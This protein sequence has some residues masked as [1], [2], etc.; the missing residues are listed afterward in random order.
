M[1][2][3]LRSTLGLASAFLLAVN[4]AAAVAQ[5]RI[6]ASTRPDFN[7]DGKDDLAVGVPGENTGAGGVHIIYG[8]RTGL[9]ELGDQFFTQASP[10]IPGGEEDYDRCGVALTTGDFNGDGYADLAFGCPSE[11]TPASE[12]AAGAVMVLYGSST[13][14]RGAGSQ[15][16]S[17]N[18]PGINGGSETLDRCG[19]SL[20]SGDINRDGFADLVWGCPG[21]DVG[22]AEDA[23][24]INIVFGSAAGLTAAGNRFVSQDSSGMPDTAEGGDSCGT[25]VGA[26]DFNADGF[27]DVVFG[28]PGEDLGLLIDAG[29]VSLAFG[30]SS[31]ISG[32]SGDFVHQN[33]SRVS[34]SEGN[35]AFDKC[36]QG[37]GVAD[38]DNDGNEDLAI[39]CPGEDVGLLTLDAGGIVLL[40]GS[41]DARSTFRSG[42]SFVL[43]NAPSRRCGA[44]IATG[45]FNGDAF[46][47][48]AYGCPETA[49]GAGDVRILAGAAGFD[50]NDVPQTP[51]S[52]NSF[53]VPDSSEAGDNFGHA[54]S[55]GDFDGDGVTDLAIGAPN[56]DLA[57]GNN[58][59]AATV[60]YFP[61]PAL[62]PIRSQFLHQDATG[63]VDLA[64]LG[65][66]FGFSLSNSSSTPLPGL[67]GRWE[68]LALWCRGASCGLTGT[69]TA[70]NPSLG[71]TPRVALRFYLSDDTALDD[72]DM[73]IDAMP[74]KP[75]DMNESQVRRLHVV[76]PP[77]TD[78]AGRFVIAFVDAE[79]IV[80]ES[81][82]ANNVVVSPQID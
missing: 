61:I 66:S 43:S 48:F 68:E 62:D 82:E 14:L 35:E 67:T 51:V 49:S 30:V 74:V 20:A 4:V 40:E 56:E 50:F 71:P 7:G 54:L 64:E 8:S 31:G 19:S 29:A 12:Q 46:A 65:D 22:S 63:I 72:A 78:A 37:L 41:S 15:F 58:V 69:F 55:A 57:A 3:S 81:N 45:F 26:G 44:A 73:L 79:D 77:G 1:N 10:D 59:G 42:R 5:V 80:E 21:E 36:G 28:C 38:F 39:G 70:I 24:A 9:T 2:S 52:Q 47:D 34:P 17:Q 32:A 27:D 16:W 6:P 53:G 13:G 75:L 25:T 33:T 18:S 11:A 23:G 76:L 60:L